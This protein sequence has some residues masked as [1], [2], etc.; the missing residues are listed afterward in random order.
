MVLAAFL[1]FTITAPDAHLQCCCNLPE[2]TSLRR[3]VLS[4]I[5]FDSS[6]YQDHSA[7]NGMADADGI[8]SIKKPETESFDP[9]V[10]TGIRK[11]HYGLSE[12]FIN[13]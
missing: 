5:K 11:G 1:Q 13:G 3:H 7:A 10:L 12:M 6:T 8:A 9:F 2:Q 4:S